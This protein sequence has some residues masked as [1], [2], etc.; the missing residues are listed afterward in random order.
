MKILQ[1]LNIFWTPDILK[2]HEHLKAF[3]IFNR[4]VSLA[5]M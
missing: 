2:L 4:V 5:G 1:Y 3:F